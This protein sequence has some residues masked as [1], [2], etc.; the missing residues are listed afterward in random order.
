MS[1]GKIPIRRPITT[2]PPRPQEQP[3]YPTDM[4]SL[5]TKGRFYPE[6]SP[7]ASGEIEIKQMTAR[8]E[9][10]LAN[11]DLIRKGKVLDKLLQ[12]LII[13]KTIDTR[14]ILISD[15]NAIFVAIRRLAYGDKYPVNFTCPACGEKSRI[16]IN[17]SEL[18][19]KDV[20]VESFPKGINNFSFTLPKS[21]TVLTYKL[22]NQ[23]DEEAIDKEIA[24][25]KKINKESSSEFTTRLKYILTS[26]NGKSDEETIRK[27]VDEEFLAID[28][29]A[30]R[31][32]MNA[33]TPD[34][35]MRFDFKCSSCEHERRMNIPVGA[36]F[37]WID[38]ES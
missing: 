32:F 2:E 36:S 38:L 5:P 33:N 16:D 24:G 4:V 18:K 1:E 10:I 25:L 23:A 35:D 14:D 37:L 12:S 11:Q 22:I 21:G 27:F 13:D 3:R 31:E 6:G 30:F 17:L 28:A 15:K 9:D 19:D 20:N 8:E 34:I 26:V 29:R 7:L